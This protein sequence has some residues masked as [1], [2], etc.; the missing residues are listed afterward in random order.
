MSLKI[1]VAFAKSRPVCMDL[2]ALLL[3][4]QGFQNYS[5]QVAVGSDLGRLKVIQIN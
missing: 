5:E 4:V 3:F 1:R 2:M